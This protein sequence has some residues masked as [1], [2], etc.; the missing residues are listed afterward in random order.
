MLSV[1][2]PRQGDGEVV[3]LLTWFEWGRPGLGQF[4][5]TELPGKPHLHSS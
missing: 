1:A 5:T 4:A 2:V 3:G